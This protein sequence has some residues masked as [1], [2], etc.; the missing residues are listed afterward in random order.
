VARVS[1]HTETDHADLTPSGIPR[2]VYQWLRFAT[3]GTPEIREQS[4]ASSVA[5]MSASI[6]LHH[7]KKHT[8]DH[9]RIREFYE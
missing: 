1:R 7:E 8:N 6:A 2:H 5:G 4:T 3:L 9:S